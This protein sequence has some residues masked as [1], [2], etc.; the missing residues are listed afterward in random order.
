MLQSKLF[1]RT[2]R[3][4]PKDESSKNA[5]LLIRGGFVDK[6]IAGVW[7]FLPLGWRVLER[8]NGIIR[9]EMERIGA[10][11]LHMPSLQP[12]EI[13]ETTDR[14]KVEEMYKLKDRG[15]RDLGLGWTHEEIITKVAM[16]FI[17][18]YRDLPQYVFQIQ[19][20]F[21]D[22]PRAKSGI[23][24]GREFLMK[25]LYSFHT[26]PEDLDSFYQ[27]ATEAYRSIFKRL[28]LDAYCVEASGGAFTKEFSHEFQVLSDA[29]EDE[30]VY[31]TKCSFARN[32]EII[33]DFKKCPNC[34]S[35]LQIGKSIEVGNIFK[36]GIKFSEAFGLFYQDEKSQKKPVVM[37]SY[38]IGPGR[39]VGTLVETHHDERG[40]IWPEVVAPFRVHILALSPK[41]K[42]FAVSIYQELQKKKVDVL[43]DDREYKTPGERFSDSDLIGIPWRV[44]VSEKTVKEDKIEVKKR[45]ET[46]VTLMDIQSFLKLVC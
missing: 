21:R 8:V 43:F 27:V 23:V 17:S 13:W 34:Q 20:K 28:D 7:T 1:S 25:D 12:R 15:G 19:T 44:V 31:C 6:L 14:W 36:L 39:L 41:V 2:L 37:G 38:G 16:P 35:E 18:S 5:E 45:S 32:K 42:E 24:R 46:D 22:E 11:E 26:T 3:E 40:I 4:A 9:E 10:V 29:G 33:A 30:I